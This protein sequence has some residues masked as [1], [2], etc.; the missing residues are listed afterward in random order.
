MR[1]RTE[2]EGEEVGGEGGEEEDEEEVGDEGEKGLWLKGSGYGGGG[3]GG[4]FGHQTVALPKGQTHQT[5]Y[6]FFLFWPLGVVR[7]GV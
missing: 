6:Y 1:G 4:G 2:E 3:G 5:H 7:L